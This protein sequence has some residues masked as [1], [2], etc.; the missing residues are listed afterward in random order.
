MIPVGIVGCAARFS[1]PVSRRPG[2]FNGFGSDVHAVLWF[3]PDV[4]PLAGVPSFKAGKVRA[5]VKLPGKT[6]GSRILMVLFAASSV[7][8][9]LQV[10]RFRNPLRLVIR[11]TGGFSVRGYCLVMGDCFLTYKNPT[12]QQVF[13]QNVYDLAAMLSGKTGSISSAVHDHC[14]FAAC[15]ANV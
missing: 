9:I 4:F 11:P 12:G 3:D 7:W 1:A 10:L 13:T 2:K 8:L 6:A 5:F 15:S 14:G